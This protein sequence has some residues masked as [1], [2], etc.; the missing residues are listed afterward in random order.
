MIW[1]A[2]LGG[3]SFVLVSLVLGPRLLALG[4]S[5]RELPELTMG[6]CLL[7]MGALG[8][9][10]AVVGRVVTALPDDVRGLFLG[11][12]AL[13]NT[14]GFAALAIFTWR[15]FRPASAIAE[16]AVAACI[17]ALA[18]LLPAEAVWPGL[19]AS[20]LSVE[21]YPGA[22]GYLRVVLGLGILYW[23]SA[24]AGLCASR[25][26]RRLAFGLADAVVA[27]RVQLWTVAMACA[28]VSYTTSF[29]LSF[30]GIDL[31]ASSLGAAI[32]GSL[33]LASAA[34][35]FLAFLPPAAYLHWVRGR[36]AAAAPA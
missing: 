10:F 32:V 21:P 16:S 5:R 34:A 31:A 25:L 14:I 4:R 17:T 22:P 19:V 35:A 30:L 6:L 15:V 27:D 12:S 1:L 9:P 18:L 24:E 23:S 7:L 36:A 33:G 11:C 29:V 8:Y 28:S 13:C 20:A 3:G 26:R 2:A